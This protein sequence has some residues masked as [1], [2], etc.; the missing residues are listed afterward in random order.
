MSHDPDVMVQELHAEFESMLNYVKDC[1]CQTKSRPNDD[2]KESQS[3]HRG[4]AIDN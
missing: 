1:F 4:V 2:R 3:C